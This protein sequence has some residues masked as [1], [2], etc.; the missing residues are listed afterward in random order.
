MYNDSWNGVP[1]ARN[2]F[3]PT[4]ERNVFGV[5]MSV[6]VGKENKYKPPV[7]VVQITFPLYRAILI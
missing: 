2:Y 7:V 6:R 1:R 4:D 5:A 3:L